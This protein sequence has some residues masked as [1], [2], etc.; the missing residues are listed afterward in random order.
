MKED[1]TRNCHSRCAGDRRPRGRWRPPSHA[2]ARP[3]DGRHATSSAPRRSRRRR[4]RQQRRCA[5]LSPRH[6]NRHCLQHRRRAQPDPGADHQ[7]HLHRRADGK[8]R[9]HARRNRS[10]SLSGPARP[11][12][13]HPRSRSGPA[14]QLAR[15][16]RPLQPIAGQGRRDDSAARHPK[17]ASPP[18]AKRH[19]I[20]RGA[21]RSRQGAARIHQA[22]LA[23]RRGHR[24]APGR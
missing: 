1:E 13:G 17:G 4:H 20:R 18:A 6:R 5:D 9:R 21:H 14:H 10:A 23:D 15:Q 8:G 12:D 7:D 22:H 24:R 3:R 16:S 19:Q 2:W 11:D